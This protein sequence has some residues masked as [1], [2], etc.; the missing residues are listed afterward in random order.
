MLGLSKREGYEDDEVQNTMKKVKKEDKKRSNADTDIFWNK[1]NSKVNSDLT[2]EGEEHE[3]YN[4][5]K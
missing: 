5:N 1:R 4:N 3:E 2:D